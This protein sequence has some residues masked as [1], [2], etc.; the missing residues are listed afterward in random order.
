MFGV[1]RKKEILL[2]VGITSRAA[3]YKRW[4]KSRKDLMMRCYKDCCLQRPHHGIKRPF[5]DAIFLAPSIGFGW[6]ESFTGGLLA[7]ILVWHYCIQSFASNV[8]HFNQHFIV[9]IISNAIANIEVLSSRT[10]LRWLCQC[11]P[12]KDYFATSLWRG[13]SSYPN[14][15]R[16]RGSGG[17]SL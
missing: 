2:M 16:H 10:L 12:S 14:T 5:K 3:H 1:W 9:F 15:Y 7:I 4:A 11:R 13:K 8:F 6:E 17:R